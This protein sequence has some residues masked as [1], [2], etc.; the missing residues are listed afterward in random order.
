VELYN[1]SGTQTGYLIAKLPDN[2]ASGINN[3][4]TG[5]IRV[6]DYTHH[7]SFDV[8]FAGYWYSGY[9]WTNCTAW[10]DS[11]SYDDRNFTVRFG[12]M[13]GAAGAGTRPYITIAESTSTWSYCKFSVINYEPGHSNYQAYKWDSGWNMD[14]SVTNPGVFA[15]TISNC[16]VNNWA[17]SGQNLYYGSGTGNVGIGTTNPGSKLEIF[18]GGNTLR[19]DSA[20]NTAKTFLMRNVNTAIAEIKTDGN[21]N[22][23]IEDASRTMRFLNGNT[24]RMRINSQGQMWLGG[25]YTGSDIANGNTTYMNNLNAGSF[26]ILHRNSSDAYVHFNSYYTSSNTYVSKYSGRGFMLG[27]NAAADT[28]FFFSKAPNTTAGQ[29]QTFSQVMTVGYG[30]SNNVGIGTT[31]PDNKLTVKATDCIIDAQS[32]ADSQTI[33]FRAGYLTNANLCGFF[34]YTT[35]DAQLYIDNNFNGN[36]GVYSDIN[37]RNKAN[38][39]T[40]LINRMKIKGSTGYV[41]IGDITPS[42][43]LD[44]AGTIRATGDVI[45]YSDVRV[46]ENIKT[47]DNSLEK[48]S[49]L[50]GVEF[51]KIGDNKK[52]IGVI[53]QEI[54]K[55]IPEVV[56]EDDKGM[57]SVA[58]GNISGLLIEAIKELKAEIEEL[59]LNKCNCNK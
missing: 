54:E 26:S 36:N 33:G 27:Y 47:I 6:F 43:K 20:G 51:N 45:A 19:M 46:K 23:N 44:V 37:F 3:M 8:H 24:E 56:K 18:G 5:V 7:E 32:T 2:G 15:R 58:Y 4:M 55:V 59:K 14:I 25:S 1:G 34:R 50:R 48:V 9:N 42:Y 28:G 53:A 40:S 31:S 16:Q 30:T 11:A 39:G 13:T 52:S 21:L 41:G 49:K 29:N 17:R 12:A 38:G 10:I 35:A 22:I 57:K